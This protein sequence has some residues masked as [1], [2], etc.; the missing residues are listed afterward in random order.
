VS[1]PGLPVFVTSSGQR[2]QLLK[3]TADAEQLEVLG[4]AIDR[5]ATIEAGGR[6]SPWVT[7]S[8]PGTGLRAWAPGARWS[9]SVRG[10]WGRST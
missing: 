3:G 8:R 1:D 10:D 5:L 2:W 9:H 7:A 4:D 6:P